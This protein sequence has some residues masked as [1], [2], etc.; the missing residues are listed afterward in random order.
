[1]AT[2][3]KGKGKTKF[4]RNRK[5]T[6]EAGDT[7]MTGLAKVKKGSRGAGKKK[8]RSKAGGRTQMPKKKTHPLWKGRDT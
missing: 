4:S 3:Q 2:F 7:A 1:V 5:R 8:V 6:R